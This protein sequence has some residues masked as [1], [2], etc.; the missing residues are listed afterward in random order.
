MKKPFCTFLLLFCVIAFARVAMASSEITT[1]PTEAK[2]T[3]DKVF[4]RSGPSTQS[5]RLTNLAI[6]SV[7][8]V[9]AREM[10]DMQY[11]WYKVRYSDG[12]GWVYG[13]YVEAI[14][15]DTTAPFERASAD[16]HYVTVV[17]IG[18]GTDRA[19]A[20]EQ[21]WIEAVR[22]AVGTI[23]SS[24]SELNNDEFAENTIAHS[25]GVIESFDVV[26]EKNDGKRTTVTIRA[27]VQKEILVD[28]AKTYSEA[29]VVK[30]DASKIVKAQMDD[31]A[32]QVT[33]EDKQKS[34]VALLKEVL[35]SYTPEMFFSATL[36]PKIYYDQKTKKPYVRVVEK[37]N[38]ELFWKE[39]LPRLHKAF[40][41]VAI[42]KT[43]HF[44]RDAVRRANQQLSKDG[45]LPEAGIDITGERWEVVPYSLLAPSEATHYYPKEIL[46]ADANSQKQI[47]LKAV[48]P[49]DNASFTV[50]NIPILYD[51]FHSSF[52][53][54]L[55]QLRRTLESQWF[56][57]P[58]NLGAIWADFWE[59]MSASVTFSITYLDKN[60]EDF[61]VQIIRTGPRH[62]NVYRSYWWKDS[63]MGMI[64]APGYVN[65]NNTGIKNLFLG[66]TNYNQK[67]D[68]G[69]EVELD[70]TELEKLDSM[71]FEV[72]FEAL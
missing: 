55:S 65:G 39:F 41:G 19:K 64:F 62:F 57:D 1:F 32:K 35:E 16:G 25:R 51:D 4:V 30:T 11:P 8:T 58:Q 24:K 29:Q 40:E 60:G 66:T 43:R 33:A 38:Q 22:L 45:Y 7:V 12:E 27:K 26:D 6:N 48:L 37:F 13:Q 47:P 70:T 34:G 50:Y 36:D 63:I 42:K 61:S 69:Y 49:N 52:A 10:G 56:D 3:G 9:L 14:N 23:I 59:K 53:P 31:K 15:D 21:A 2:L 17:A 72:I 46:Q 28:A 67:Y 18:Q 44:Y 20:L 68:G 5:Q 71:K 54:S